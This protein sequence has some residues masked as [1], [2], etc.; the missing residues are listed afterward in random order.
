MVFSTFRHN[1]ARPIVF[2][3]PTQLY[4]L[5]PLG[6]IPHFGILVGYAMCEK[7][8]GRCGTL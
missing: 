2:S 1:H 8:D 3:F 6:F 7:V 5:S 4:G